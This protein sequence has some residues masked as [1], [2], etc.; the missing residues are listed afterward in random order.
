MEVA[1]KQKI[2]ALQ[3][4]YSRGLYYRD[5]S[6]FNKT[7]TGF[8]TGLDI[9]FSSKQKTSF[10]IGPYLNYGITKIANEGY[11]KHHFTFIG[12]KAQYLFRK[13]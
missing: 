8:N 1:N 7:Q 9:G 13:K 5:N 10:L 4:N 12:L 11:N 3:F 2:K 6:L